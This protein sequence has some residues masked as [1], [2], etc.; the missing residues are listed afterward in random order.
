MTQ[1]ILM[2]FAAINV[3]TLL[4]SILD[5]GLAVHRCRRIPERLL[6]TFSFL[7][8]AAGAKLAQ[9]VSGHKSLKV[10]FTASLSLIAFLQLGIAGAVWSESVR[11]GDDAILT[12]MAATLEQ[13]EA[14][15]VQ[16]VAEE[17]AQPR[18]FGPG[19]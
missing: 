1:T 17:R 12:Q 13:D 18:R 7:G 2:Y 4:V 16:Y 9:I 19:S 11:G 3:V 15:E 10:D 6:L 5:K 8:G 14:E